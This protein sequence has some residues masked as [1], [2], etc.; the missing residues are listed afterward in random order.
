MVNNDSPAKI[1]DLEPELQRLASFIV[2]HRLQA[3]AL[4]LLEAHLP[5]VSLA[6]TASLFIEP[7]ASAFV[8]A[9]R[10]QS[11]K[12]LL[13]DRK[14]VEELIRLIEQMSGGS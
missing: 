6:H 9:E 3:P 11:L 7:M 10:I 4:L 8:G 14:N 5:L 13:S 2:S 1:H 12:H